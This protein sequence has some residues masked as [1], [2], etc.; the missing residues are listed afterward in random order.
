MP[1]TDGNQAKLAQFIAQEIAMD[2]RIPQADGSAVK[3]VIE[4]AK[5]RAFVLDRRERALTLRLRELGGLIRTAGDLA[6]RQKAEIIRE[7]HID[8]ALRRSK[9]IEEQVKE[10]YGTYQR[11]VASDM[12]GAQKQSSPYHYWNTDFYDDKTGYE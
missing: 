12:T 1:D 9:T 6:I 5:R 10:K 2:G 7:K 3:A 8:M 4:E 11:G